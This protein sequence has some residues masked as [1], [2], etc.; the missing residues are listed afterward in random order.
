MAYTGSCLCG[1]IA[2]R[3]ESELEPIQVCHCTQCRKAQGGPFA[4][5]IPVA[6]SAFHLLSGEHLLQSYESSPGKQR[7]FCRSFGAPVYSRRQSLP[8]VIR[9]RAGLFDEPLPVKPAWHAY[10]GSK[11]NWWSI[12][13][14]LPQY[15]G[16]HVP[17][18]TAIGP[19]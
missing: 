18:S 9:V 8:A 14:G 6:V 11:C 1:G 16:S 13:D 17:P 19:E 2:F 15:V 3:V 12:Q 5:V 10:T 4:A 7:V